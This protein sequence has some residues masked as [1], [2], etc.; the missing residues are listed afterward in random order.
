MNNTRHHGLPSLSIAYAKQS[1]GYVEKERIAGM[2]HLGIGAF[3]RAHQAWYTQKAMELEGGNWYVVGVSLRSA[4]VASQLNPQNGLYTIVEQS[5]DSTTCCVNDSVLDVLVAP[6]SPGKVINVMSQEYIHIVTLSITEKGYCSEPASG[7]LNIKHPDIVHDLAHLESPITAI[8]F[9]VA[10]I[11]HRIKQNVPPFTVISCDN[12]PENGR[13]LQQMVLSF[14]Q[15]ISPALARR[16]ETDYCFPCTMVDRIVPAISHDYRL[17]YTKKLGYY[18]AGLVLTEPFTQWVIEDC[19]A[20]PRPAWEHA[21]ALVTNDVAAF[22]TMKLRLLNGSHS[23]IAYLGFLANKQYVADVMSVN[24][25]ATFIRYVMLQELLP[26]V[27]VPVGIDSLHYCEQLTERFNNPNLPYRTDQIATDGSQKLPQRLLNPLRHQ[28]KHDANITGICYVLA[29]WMVYVSGSDLASKP[30]E[31]KD[32]LATDLAQMAKKYKQNN[33][34]WVFNILCIDAIFGKDL[35][36]NSRLCDELTDCLTK[37]RE[38][39]D[40]ESTLSKYMDIGS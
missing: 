40:V 8:G 23:A 35:R 19:F 33:R 2:V 24:T 37:L 38:S 36:H 30:I 10:A 21:G 18:D 26:S 34:E 13:L 32:P 12:L 29:A 1:L 5:S 14:A 39:A 11:K 15:H 22:E 6:E 25:L 16:I 3:H 20:G 7:E 31:V 17:R 9:L 28:L 4:N 27:K